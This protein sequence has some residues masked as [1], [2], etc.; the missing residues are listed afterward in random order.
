MRIGIPIARGHRRQGELAG[1]QTRKMERRKK[2]LMMK[3]DEI[4]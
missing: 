4:N 3:S 1:A 2:R